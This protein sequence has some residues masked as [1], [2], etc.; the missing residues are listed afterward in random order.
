MNT[1]E[2]LELLEENQNERGIAHWNKR[3]S[4]LTSYGIGL[5]Q[6]RK[7]AKQIG[8]DHKLAQQLWKSE[9]YDA[10]VVG[11]LIDEPKKMT[12]EQ[13]ETHGEHAGIVGDSDGLRYVLHKVEQGAL[14]VAEGRHVIV[15]RRRAEVV[16]VVEGAKLTV[17][18]PA[19]RDRQ[20]TQTAAP[21]F[22]AH[23][24][25]EDAVTEDLLGDGAAGEL[26]DFGPGQ[27]QPIPL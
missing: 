2:V 24:Q 19:G 4:K 16:A 14:V 25:G 12:R 23:V 10:R 7:L 22:V 27:G 13:V 8:R 26:V 1:K 15:T 11:T 20:V 5:T 6:L 3:P 9:Y 18:M 21:I 17:G